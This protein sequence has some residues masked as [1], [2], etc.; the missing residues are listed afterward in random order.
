MSSS[1]RPSPNEVRSA[2]SSGELEPGH[3]VGEVIGVGADVAERP[4]GARALRIG[5]P[6]GLLVAALLG[7][8]GQPVLRIFDLHQPKDAEIAAL[9][10]LAHPA[11]Q[12]IAGVIVGEGEEAARLLDRRLHPL[13]FG[14][15]HR[16]RLVADDVDARLQEGDGRPGVHVVG[17]DDRNR[18]DPVRPLGL[19]LRH[20]LVVVV[21]AVGRKSK[22]FARPA[23]L[24]RR[25]RQ[26]AGDQFV[27]VVD[28]RGDAV[29]RADEGALAAAHH[30][31]PDA[32]AGLG[33]AASLDGHLIPPVTSARARA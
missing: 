23:R 15:R 24:L 22:G 8:P 10:H 29:H 17:G 33:V 18:L 3:V 11:H 31:E 19:R 21:D 28:A 13:G 27:L 30:A 12:R 6:L 2:E 14:E 26:R 4:A 20:A 25:R 1:V 32:S 7:R 9:D 16:Q 5:A